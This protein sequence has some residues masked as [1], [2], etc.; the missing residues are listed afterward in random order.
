[1]VK[2]INFECL[3]LQKRLER[4][5]KP[6]YYSKVF[7]SPVYRVHGT[8]EARLEFQCKNLCKEYDKSL[9]I[10][11]NICQN[12]SRPTKPAYFFPFC[13]NF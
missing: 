3:G 13:F 5:S 8:Q 7:V 10:L 11:T 6:V 4:S 9:E 12:L 2:S 1:M